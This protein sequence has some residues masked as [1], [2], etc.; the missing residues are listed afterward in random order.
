MRLN[1]LVNVD[2]FGACIDTLTPIA[3]G[4]VDAWVLVLEVKDFGSIGGSIIVNG[5]WLVLL[6]SDDDDN[7]DDDDDLRCTNCRVADGSV[8]LCDM[9]V[10]WLCGVNRFS[11]LSSPSSSLS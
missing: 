5:W 7:V 9:L 1:G 10:L 6:S 2:V 11:S 8:I 3:D 4:A